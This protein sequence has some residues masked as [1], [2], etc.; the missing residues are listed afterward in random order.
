MSVPLLGSCS[1]P[2][3]SRSRP[4][5][6]EI[7]PLE[8]DG[9]A[10][11]VPKAW[12][13]GRPWDARPWRNGVRAGTGGWGQFNPTV[14]PLALAGDYGEHPKDGIYRATSKG[15]K[16]D[17]RDPF[18]TLSITFEFPLPPAKDSWWG[19]STDNRVFPFSFDRLHISY[20]APGERQ[21][22]YLTLLNNL[23]P[24]DGEDLGDGWRMVSREYSNRTVWF[25]FDALDWHARGGRLPR[26]LASS[27][28]RGKGIWY[29]YLPLSP[30][31]W[32]ADFLTIRLPVSRWRAKYAAAETLYD[33]LGTSPAKRNYAK[34][35]VWWQDL[36]D[37]PTH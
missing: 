10:I 14:G 25:R 35:F 8:I 33:W 30:R 13:A 22:P 21:M 32:S 9:T 29:H 28:S 23:G 36:G 3:P 24:D 18:F 11:F 20:H 6:D 4:M 37:R 26:H 12:N 1:D 17:P 31:G 16:V 5:P 2:S 27:D 15:Q 34:R 19:K 7:V